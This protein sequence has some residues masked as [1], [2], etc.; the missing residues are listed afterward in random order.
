M[1]T[2]SQVSIDYKKHHKQALLSTVDWVAIFAFVAVAAFLIWNAPYGITEVDDATYQTIQQRLTKGDKLIADEWLMVLLNSYFWYL[3]YHFF[4]TILGGTEGIIL[5]L[6]YLHCVI[7]LFFFWVVYVSFRK[8]RYWAI[9]A[10]IIYVGFDPFGIKTQNY[11]S[12]CSNALLLMEIL[13][14]V[15]EET[16]PIHYCF[17]GFLLSCAVVSEPSIG[18][19]WVLFCGLTLIS[20]LCKKK[21]KRLPTFVGFLPDSRTWKFMVLGIVVA[22]VIFVF[23]GV[24]FFFGTDWKMLVSGIRQMIIDSEYTPGGNILNTLRL[25]KIWRSLKLYNLPAFFLFLFVLLLSLIIHHVSDKYDFPLFLILFILFISLSVFLLLQPLRAYPFAYG[26]CVSHP[27]L[28]AVMGIPAYAFAKQK[29]PQLFTFLLVSF[30][31]SF[32]VDLISDCA[33]GSILLPGDVCAVIL[34]R[35]YLTEF[36]LSKITNKKQNEE[37]EKTKQRQ[38]AV[39]WHTDNIT[40]KK[41]CAVVIVLFIVFIESANYGYAAWLHETE[42]LYCGSDEPLDQRISL[43]AYKGIKTI[44]RIRNDFESCAMDMPRVR[45]LCNQGLFIPSI[46]PGL[47]LDADLNISTY[48][49]LAY[50]LD[51]W[52]QTE[53]WWKLHPNK[54]PD[55]IYV[56]YHDLSYFNKEDE[57]MEE[58]LEHINTLA[59]Y[60]IEDGIGGKIIKIISWH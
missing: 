52:Q 36:F 19:L 2:I 29:N 27:L 31:S 42:Y 16:K 56:P 49:S 26:Q 8:Y 1:K 35:N 45:E 37:M 51:F 32:C 38:N 43:G 12:F 48:T 39:R 25:Y 57:T 58:K 33:F 40:F 46:A 22:F 47:Y 9:L 41:F 6:R 7:K 60:T 4:Y 28:L 44:Q 20:H 24:F 50:C 30:L 18:F 34:L 23:C 5:C 55:V 3:P 15:K 59:D 10:A 13:L 14:F 21:N 54:K 17:A 53:L 11:Y